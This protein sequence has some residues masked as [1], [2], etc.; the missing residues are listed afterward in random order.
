MSP[1]RS[2]TQPPRRVRHRS[3]D[4]RQ[5]GRGT[6]APA[7][8]SDNAIQK[9]AA[10]RA[11]LF[12]ARNPPATDTGRFEAAVRR[13]APPGFL[14]AG[15]QPDATGRSC[16]SGSAPA[17][18]GRPGQ[19]SESRGDRG[20][21][22]SQL[23]RPAAVQSRSAPASVRPRPRHTAVGGHERAAVG[24]DDC[25]VSG[26]GGDEPTS[27]R[28]VPAADRR[29]KRRPSLVTQTVPFRPT[30]QQTEPPGELPAVSTS[31][32]AR[33]HRLPGR[34]RPRMNAAA[35]RPRRCANDARHQATRRRAGHERSRRR[36]E[37]NSHAEAEVE[38]LPPP[39]AAAAEDVTGAGVE[40]CCDGRGQTAGTGGHPLRRTPTCHPSARR[41]ESLAAAG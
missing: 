2:R 34:A 8:S 18:A 33:R 12:E 39:P 5:D 13:T 32:V 7:A 3:D 24:G 41:A 29:S 20:S 30:S 40:R 35:A 6:T 26:V 25:G 4:G 11:P 36:C 1:D 19:D 22:S 9:R 10:M 21:V 17:P 28:P 27:D 15:L 14:A 16:R 38:T 37:R 23:W 31:A